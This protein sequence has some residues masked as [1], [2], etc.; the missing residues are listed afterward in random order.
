[1]IFVRLLLLVILVDGA[2][3]PS[4]ARAASG[5]PAAG[6]SASR[7]AHSGPGSCELVG[8]CDCCLADP[9]EAARPFEH[10]LPNC[11]N[12]RGFAAISDPFTA[13]HVRLP[14]RPPIAA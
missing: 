11:T 1:M 2:V 8:F 13:E 7:D 14:F 9:D 6:P 12:A 10:V 3:S 4:V 5:T